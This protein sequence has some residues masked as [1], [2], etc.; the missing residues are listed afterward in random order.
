MVRTL[1]VAILVLIW[2]GQAL[3]FEDGFIW[4]GVKGQ[5]EV[6]YEPRLITEQNSEAGW[7]ALRCNRTSKAISI[8]FCADVKESA[9]G[10]NIVFFQIDSQILDYM[11]PLPSEEGLCSPTPTVQVKGDDPLIKA[12]MSGSELKLHF[13]SVDLNAPD[14]Q[15][16]LSNTR[17]LFTEHLKQCL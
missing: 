7:I 3:A 12:L 1:S 14:D 16:K 8:E 5:S 15:A 10:K 6:R 4:K 17:K 13:G 11:G 2:A 9:A